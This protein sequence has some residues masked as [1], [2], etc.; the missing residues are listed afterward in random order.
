MLLAEEYLEK[1]KMEKD[2][3]AR[4]KVFSAI[5]E[6]YEVERN[7][8]RARTGRFICVTGM[9]ISAITIFAFVSTEIGGGSSLGL[10]RIHDITSKHS[11]QWVINIGG[12]IHVPFYV[13]FFGIL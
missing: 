9:V 8:Q 11:T 3:D 13:F 4:L 12:T 1:R 7:L 5:H 6:L 10:V 2:K